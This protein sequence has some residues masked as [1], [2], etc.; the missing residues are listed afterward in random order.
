L[1]MYFMFFIFV[2]ICRRE[3]LAYPLV[4]AVASLYYLNLNVEDPAVHIALT[5]LRVSLGLVVGLRFGL[6]AFLAMLFFYFTS[7][8][9]S[10]EFAVWYWPSRVVIV[11]TLVG[12]AAFGLFRAKGNRPFFE[13]G[14]FGDA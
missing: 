1:V 6:W 4:V 9:A 13:R 10:L 8:S 12:L 3:W 2:L 5:T 14:L 7:L 11:G